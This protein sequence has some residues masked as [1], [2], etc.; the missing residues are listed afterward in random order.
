MFP[1]SRRD[2]EDFFAE[3]YQ[4]P[5]GWLISTCAYGTK[6]VAERRRTLAR[7][8]SVWNKQVKKFVLKGQGK[9]ARHAAPPFMQDDWY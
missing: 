7:H 4:P 8:V 9:Q 3:R 6:F 5:C 2:G 1:P